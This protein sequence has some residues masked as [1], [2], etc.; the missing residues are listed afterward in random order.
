MARKRSRRAQIVRP[1]RSG[2]RRTKITLSDLKRFKQELMSRPDVALAEF[3]RCGAAC[4]M[5]LPTFLEI[6]V[7]NR[8]RA[9]VIARVA[10]GMKIPIG[11]EALDFFLQNGPGQQP[12]DDEIDDVLGSMKPGEV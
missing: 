7:E 10:A 2:S 9:I 11:D 4:L 5:E 3:R 12:S 8:E 6:L 1:G